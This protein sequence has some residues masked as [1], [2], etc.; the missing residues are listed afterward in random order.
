MNLNRST[1]FLDDS[2]RNRSRRVDDN[3][4]MF[5]HVEVASTIGDLSTLARQ[6]TG[7]L[8][9]N[10]YSVLAQRP[11]DLEIFETVKEFGQVCAETLDAIV[12]GGRR[13]NGDRHILSCGED[14]WL[15]HEKNTWNLLYCL[16][17]DRLVN[18]KEDMDTD[19]FGLA[20]SERQIVEQLYITNAN[21]REYQL[22]VDWLELSAL[23]DRGAVQIG[24]YTDRT[25]AWE[26]TLHQLQNLETMFGS[27]REIVRHVDPDAPARER[28]PL[29]DL[30]AADEARLSKQVFTAIRQGRFD[31]AQTIC[32]HCGQPWRAALLEGWRLHHDPNYFEE[33]ANGKLPVEGNP[34][35]DLWKKCAWMMADNEKLDEYSRATAGVFCGHLEAILKCATEYAD[36]LWAYMKV[37]IDIR[38]ESEIRSAS[39]RNYL[40]MPDVYWNKNKMSLEQIFDEL[41]AHKSPKI[42]TDAQ[43]PINVIQKYLILDNVPELLRHVDTWLTDGQASPQMLRLLT[44]IVMFMR[45]VGRQHQEDVADRVIKAYVEY[46]FKLKDSQMVAFYA[47]ALPRDLQISMYSR[48]ME[49]VTTDR[50]RCLEEAITAG[51]DIQ[52]ITSYTVDAVRSRLIDDE[53]SADDVGVELQDVIS[54]EDERRISTLEWLTF[55]PQQ[56]GELMWQTNAFIRTFLASR[57]IAAVKKL[58]AVIPKDTVAILCSSYGSKEDLPHR[59]ECSI[60]EHLSYQAYLAALDGYNDWSYLY[61]SRP[62]P[63]QLAKPGANF[64]EK[65]ASEHRE[66]AYRAELDNWDGQ[67][68]SQTQRTKDLLYNIILFPDSGWLVDPDAI[69]M[70]PEDESGVWARRF[71]QLES[72]R[73]IYVPEVVLLLHNTLHLAEEFQDCVRLA[74]EIVSESR[75]IYKVFSKQ[76][77][78]EVLMKLSESSLSLMNQHN[79]PWGY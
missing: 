6:K 21:L 65:V 66:N 9:Q 44:H 52:A 35:R 23:D 30:D 60:K 46:L 63:P 58:F 16:Y 8:Y 77:L 59:D 24:H 70:V 50:K 11:N 61:H 2:L 79:D 71:V 12:E 26:N 18:Q 45:Q 33:T 20:A 40:E 68:K 34:R 56:R 53:D 22:I 31:D 15:T 48:Y 74:D 41:A 28:R 7:Q 10:F 64:T 55:Y 62:K 3:E 67:L 76:K 73:K 38:V 42:G 39:M 32:E 72:L 69:K 75:Q 19:D 78:E 14:V 17:K 37:Q 4:S 57:K 51:L 25:V 5:S 49:T 54:P 36:H 13:V 47:A 27:G 43:R 29:H 1:I